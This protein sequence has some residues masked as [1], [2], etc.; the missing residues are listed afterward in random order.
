MQ[1][2]P[3]YVENNS[4][5][6]PY[7]LAFPM[8]LGI[9]APLE[10]SDLFIRHISLCPCVAIVYSSQKFLAIRGKNECALCNT[11]PQQLQGSREDPS[12]VEK[13]HPFPEGL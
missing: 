9:P 2:A 6:V 3:G 12:W 7:P 5:S 11:H 1:T 4:L 13:E 10:D 8:L